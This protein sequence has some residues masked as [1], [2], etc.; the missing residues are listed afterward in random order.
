MGERPVGEVE[1]LCSGVV[2]KL[3]EMLF[4]GWAIAIGRDMAREEGGLLAKRTA[5]KEEWWQ[6]CGGR[7]GVEMGVGMM[8][9]V[10]AEREESE[11]DTESLEKER[12]AGRVVMAVRVSIEGSVGEGLEVAAAAA[13]TMVP[14]WSSKYCERLGRDLTYWRLPVEEDMRAYAA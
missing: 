11:P 12:G 6:S 13:A 7:E 1:G 5:V 9:G 2:A 3:L 14:V 4:G 8:V 10:A